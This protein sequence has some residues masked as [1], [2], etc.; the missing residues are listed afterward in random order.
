MS[1]ATVADYLALTKPKITVYVVMTATLGFVLASG[2]VLDTG[3]LAVLLIGTTLV[4]GGTNALNMWWERE[5][6]ARMIRTRRRPVASGR[7]APAHAL[8]F[9]LVIGAVGTLMLLALTNAL[10][11]T[12]AALTL[13][14]YV[15]VYTPLK[16]RTAWNT[17]I[18]CVPGALPILG[19][20]TAAGGALIAEAW[21][22]FGLLYAWQ[23][24]HTL[25]LAWVLREE[26]ARGGLKMPGWDDPTGRRTA[27]AAVAGAALLL[28]ISI[29]LDPVDA[30]YLLVA[31][32]AGVGLVGIAVHWFVHPARGPARRVFLATLAY[33]PVVLA[34]LGLST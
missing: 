1:F 7:I 31:L 13:A 16:R 2:E 22:L 30:V 6:D 27:G 20:W 29:L 23:L 8:T 24:P 21:L 19:G 33:L 32:T 3:T 12:L 14:S 4:S 10:T 28:A 11:A 25:A 9:G 5:I 15:L 34:A 18:G 26:Y 17:L